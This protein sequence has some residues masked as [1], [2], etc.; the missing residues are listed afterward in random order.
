M[1]GHGLFL[2]ILRVFNQVSSG[3]YLSFCKPVLVLI[4]MSFEFYILYDFFWFCSRFLI[5]GWSN[6]CHF[7]DFLLL[8]NAMILV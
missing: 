4:T 2:G 1:R 8:M 5:Y 6:D 7:A 3:I